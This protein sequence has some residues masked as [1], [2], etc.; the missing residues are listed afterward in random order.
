MIG[1]FVVLSCFFYVSIFVLNKNI[2]MWHLANKNLLVSKIGPASRRGPLLQISFEKV[3]LARIWLCTAAACILVP[4]QGLMQ[5]VT[6]RHPNNDLPDEP[7]AAQSMLHISQNSKELKV[8]ISVPPQGPMQV[9]TSRHPNKDLPDEPFAAQSM[10]HISQNSKGLKVFLSDP[11]DAGCDI[12]PTP[13]NN[14]PEKPAISHLQSCK[15]VPI[16][17]IYWC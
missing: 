12:T 6:S 13:N 10:L 7:F 16:V 17:P 5:V 3:K 15:N 1:V 4:P 9:V 11:P 14:L 8:F 2:S